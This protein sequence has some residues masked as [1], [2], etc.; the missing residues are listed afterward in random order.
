MSERETTFEIYRRVSSYKDKAPQAES[1]PLRP[2]AYVNDGRSV[3]ALVRTNNRTRGIIE[4]LGIIGG[5]KPTLAELQ[6]YVLVKP[7]L[8]SHDLFPGSTHPETLRTILQVMIET[9]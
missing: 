6:G 9:G 5:L 7:N 3:V 1:K 2:N 4:A 8:N